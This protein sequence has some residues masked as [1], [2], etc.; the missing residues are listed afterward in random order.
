[1]VHA[2]RMEVVQQKVA[3]YVAQLVALDLF[4]FGLS[5]IPATAA[6]AMELNL[7]R[8]CDAIP[9]NAHLVIFEV[10]T[11]GCEML[12]SIPIRVVVHA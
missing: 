6:A 10:F 4:T 8:D 12:F 1:V 9:F 11:K 5:F 7:V 2:G 3:F